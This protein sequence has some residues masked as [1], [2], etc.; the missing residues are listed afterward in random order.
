MITT[1]T[2]VT[3]SRRAPGLP[4]T[5]VEGDHDPGI[6][7]TLRQATAS[8]H[9]RAEGA[10]FVSD[11]MGGRLGLADYASL[12]RANLTIY[13]ALEAAVDGLRSDPLCVELFD[14][15]LDRLPRLEADDA[16]LA[17]LLSDADAARLVVA[18]SGPA[19]SAYV[20]RL[21][22][23]SGQPVRMIA[24]HYTRYLGDLSGGQAVA[25]MVRRHITA[26]GLS[27]YDFGDIGALPHY[28]KRYRAALDALPIDEAELAEL[29]DEA[30]ISFALNAAVFADLHQ[31]RAC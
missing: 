21:Q 22:L 19:V 20:S 23:I 3:P 31:A 11:L 17:A 1:E 30:Q 8:A 24:H 7:T 28:K 6:A 29:V 26:A 2:L 27:F 14:P 12:V 13:R 9:E 16:E 10:T 18:E 4:A 15:A 25:A 5:Q